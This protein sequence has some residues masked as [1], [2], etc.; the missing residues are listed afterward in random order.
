MNKELG[1]VMPAYNEE[2]NLEKTVGDLLRTAEKLNVVMEIVVVNDGS[3]DN[4]SKIVSA[5]QSVDPRIIPVEHETNRGFGGAVRTGIAH[6]TKDRLLLVPADGQFDPQ[7]T[8]KFLSALDDC[9]LIIGVRSKRS[10]Y[11]LFRQ[12]VSFI[13]ISLVKLLFNDCYRDTNWVQAWR[14]EI[15]EK[16][17]PE[18]EGVFI[19]QETIT[20]A[21]RAGYRIGEVESNHLERVDGEAQGGKLKVILFT[22]YEMLKFRFKLN[23]PSP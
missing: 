4:T 6:S 15:F 8:E 5:M 1:I 23:T 22:L 14:R 9:D 13:Y 19:L 11:S 7:E 21:R 3:S 20:R 16:V 18:S 2:K 17:K 12:F 10:G